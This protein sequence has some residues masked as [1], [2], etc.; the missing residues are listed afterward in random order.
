[1][2]FTQIKCAR[3]FLL[4][5]CLS[6]DPTTRMHLLLGVQVH[7][8]I[9]CL[10]KVALSVYL[11]K[12]LSEQ[13]YACS[14]LSLSAFVR[15]LPK[16][17]TCELACASQGC[18]HSCKQVPRVICNGA[19]HGN[20]HNALVPT[21]VSSL[22]GLTLVRELCEHSLSPCAGPQIFMAGLKLRR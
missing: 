20:L 19:H 2:P 21:P 8:Q 14:P 6:I 13:R 11:K 3:R 10:Q 1:M 12:L 15:L 9:A 18:S 22:A 16:L 5:K 4:Q 17:K 7:K